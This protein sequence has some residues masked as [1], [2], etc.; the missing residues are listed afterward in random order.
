[1]KKDENGVYW[2]DGKIEYTNDTRVLTR[3]QMKEIY[4]MRWVGLTNVD[5]DGACIHSG[6]VVAFGDKSELLLLQIDGKLDYVTFT[7]RERLN[8]VDM[9]NAI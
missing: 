4:P 8:G 1:M 9:I 3:E 7:T 2:E 6:T 5:R